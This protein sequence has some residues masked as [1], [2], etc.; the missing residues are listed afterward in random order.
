MYH[1]VYRIVIYLTIFGGGPYKQL[2]QNLYES[3]L[4]YQ[5]IQAL[6]SNHLKFVTVKLLNILLGNQTVCY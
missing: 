4:F 2:S 3:N 5:S 1:V 6:Q